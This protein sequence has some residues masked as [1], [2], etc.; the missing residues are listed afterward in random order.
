MGLLN[1]SDLLYEGEYSWTAIDN[2][3]PKI[4]V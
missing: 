2:D 3:T 1:K 4:I